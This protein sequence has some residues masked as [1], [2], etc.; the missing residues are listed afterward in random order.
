[1]QNCRDGQKFQK[2]QA[3]VED[4]KPEQGGHSPS[5]VKRIRG[6]CVTAVFD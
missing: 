2:D 6:R 4:P 5:T 3:P 1:M